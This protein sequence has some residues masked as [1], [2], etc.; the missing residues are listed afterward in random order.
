[1]I[2]ALKQK[3]I[4]TRNDKLTSFPACLRD[5]FIERARTAEIG[6]KK[7]ITDE[8]L[9]D[10]LKCLSAHFYDHVLVKI[11]QTLETDIMF[12]NIRGEC[13]RTPDGKNCMAPTPEEAIEI[14]EVITTFAILADALRGA[15]VLK[16]CGGKKSSCHVAKAEK[17]IEIIGRQNH[18]SE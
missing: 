2:A 16:I 5:A 6:K 7:E 8:R 1:M 10:R 4:N 15:V 12:C 17:K 13:K 9:V 14:L 18:H 3:C 11:A